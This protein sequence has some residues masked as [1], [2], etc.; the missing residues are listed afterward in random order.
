MCVININHDIKIIKKTQ[1][2]QNEFEPECHTYFLMA[3]FS[4]LSIQV[5]SNT[6]PYV[7]SPS[8]FVTEYRFMVD[9][10][11]RYKLDKTSWTL[12]SFVFF[13][14]IFSSCKVLHT[15]I[16]STVWKTVV[17]AEMQHVWKLSSVCCFFYLTWKIVNHILFTLQQF[18]EHKSTV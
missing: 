5:A 17:V 11:S 4:L 9:Y 7:P 10:P 1:S 12:L 14:S 16:P 18:P 2:K 13:F 6:L 15:N 3:T 8:C